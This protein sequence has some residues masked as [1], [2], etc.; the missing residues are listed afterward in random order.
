M[1]LCCNFKKKSI[2]RCHFLL[3]SLLICIK[4]LGLNVGFGL[5]L[6]SIWRRNRNLVA[7]LSD[8]LMI[9]PLY[10]TLLFCSARW[11]TVAPTS[12]SFR[13]EGEM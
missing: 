4:T 3:E 10:R 13:E 1:H 7:P 5:F 6:A 11:C 12:H 8:D 9:F 2:E